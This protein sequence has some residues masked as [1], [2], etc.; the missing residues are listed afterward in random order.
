M[1][2]FGSLTR[3]LREKEDE[4]WFHLMSRPQ[5]WCTKTLQRLL[6]WTPKPIRGIGPLCYVKTFCRS[7]KFAK[8]LTTWMKMLYSQ[9][10]K[11]SDYREFELS[12]GSKPKN[13]NKQISKWDGEGQFNYLKL[14]FGFI[15]IYY[16]LFCFSSIL[17]RRMLTLPNKRGSEL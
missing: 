8:L 9:L 13:E 11:S 7:D 2:P 5:Y 1:N 4:E 12:R 14:R 6:C 17:S 3:L 10:E 15:L 16:V